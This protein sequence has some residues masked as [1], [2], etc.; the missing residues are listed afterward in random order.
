MRLE[1][2]ARRTSLPLVRDVTESLLREAR[3]VRLE[4]ELVCDLQLAM[5]EACNNVI[6]HAYGERSGPLIVSLTLID[7]QLTIEVID[8]GPGFSIENV[9]SP[10]FS[11]DRE[12]SP[13]QSGYGLSLMKQLV[14]EVSVERR[15]ARN[16]VTLRKKFT[17]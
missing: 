17:A 10:Q 7:D 13:P 6:V 4:D 3:D 2:V 5:Q 11:D 9:P 15:G 1:L 12:N 14:D 8:E 16:V